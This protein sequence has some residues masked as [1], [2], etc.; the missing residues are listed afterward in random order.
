MSTLLDPSILMAI[1]DLS[2]AAK[3]TIDG[4]MTGLHQSRVKGPGLEFSQYRS[5][6]PGDDLRWL[7]WK[8]YGRSDRYYIRESEI[9]TSISVRFILDGSR[10]MDHSDGAFTKIQYARYLAACLGYLAYLQGD[11]I[12]LSVISEGAVQNLPSRRD[13]AQLA[14]FIYQLEQIRPQGKFPETSGY[15]AL[16]GGEATPQKSIFI[17]ISDLYEYQGE[18]VRLLETLSALGHEVIALHLMGNNELTM[19]FSGYS[20]LEDLE[21]GEILPFH[22]KDQVTAYAEKLQVYLQSLRSRLHEKRIAYR[23]MTLAQ[24]PA[25]ALREFLQMRQHLNR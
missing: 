14:R 6:Q 10:S 20:A 9:E 2:L 21:T 7:D 23:L 1:K 18:V 15:R 8:M 19:D 11:A 5:Y 25:D 24:A 12:G 4:F 13:P 16:F 22:V 17:F 3:L